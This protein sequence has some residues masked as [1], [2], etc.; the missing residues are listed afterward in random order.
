MSQNAR[1]D[2]FD[3]NEDKNK[4]MHV[5]NSSFCN[6]IDIFFNWI[7][8]EETLRLSVFN[9]KCKRHTIKPWPQWPG[10]ASI[11][12]SNQILAWPQKLAWPQI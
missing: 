10:L 5:R 3:Y 12:A 7:K 2:K 9:T 11:L 6:I 8:K 4:V 1:S